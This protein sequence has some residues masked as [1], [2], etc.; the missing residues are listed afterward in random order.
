[1]KVLFLIL[2]THTARWRPA[3]RTELFNFSYTYN[4]HS[5]NIVLFW[6]I[7]VRFYLY[8]ML[9]NFSCKQ[10]RTNIYSLNE[11]NTCS[12]LCILTGYYLYDYMTIL[13]NAVCYSEMEKISE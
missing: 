2:R 10:N 12:S 9:S 11:K 8:L 13:E 4:K 7:F 1:M 5:D 6:P 3:C